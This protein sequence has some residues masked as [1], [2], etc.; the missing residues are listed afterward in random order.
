MLLKKM[1]NRPIKLLSTEDGALWGEAI[2]PVAGLLSP[3]Q[4]SILPQESQRTAVR[5]WMAMGAEERVIAFTGLADEDLASATA[6]G[7][8]I[9][10]SQ[11]APAQVVLVSTSPLANP[12]AGLGM[13]DV[14]MGKCTLE[15]VLDEPAEGM[16]WIFPAGKMPE[17]RSMLFSSPQCAALLSALKDRFKYVL[18]DA[19]TLISPASLLLIALCDAVAV[20]LQA[21]SHRQSDLREVQSELLRT[22]ARMLGVLLTEQKG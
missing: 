10:F 11:F 17:D 8:A 19:G 16:P 2:K 18:V 22:R 13:A 15:S 12:L 6:H 9:A 14:L 20:A 4:A 21:G 7:M 5:L 3:P 1:P